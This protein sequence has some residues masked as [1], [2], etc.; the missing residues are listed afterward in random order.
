[1][2]PPNFRPLFEGIKVA[3]EDDLDLHGDIW[4]FKS[5]IEWRVA[6]YASLT[7]GVEYNRI[8]I[9]AETDARS[10]RVLYKDEYFGP[11]VGL[12]VRF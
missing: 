10:L 12:L 7:A 5:T 8:D 11:R 2:H 6:K 9:E 3:L 1:M 4:G